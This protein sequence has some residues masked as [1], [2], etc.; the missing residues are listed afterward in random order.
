[1]RE[2]RDA[3]LIESTTLTRTIQRMLNRSLLER[4]SDPRDRRRV[5]VFLTL[6]G[7][8]LFHSVRG[9]VYYL[10]TLLKSKVQHI[11]LAE[12]LKTLLDTINEIA[13]KPKKPLQL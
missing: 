11:R 1:M 12:T 8:R 7:K 3:V 13:E 2:L 9:A 6:S 5:I 10:D 4:K